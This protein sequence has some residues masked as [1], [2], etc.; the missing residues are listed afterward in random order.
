MCV[1]SRGPYVS[2]ASQQSFKY[3]WG[4]RRTIE[5]FNQYA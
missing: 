5:P 3:E 4:E 2:T 1:V